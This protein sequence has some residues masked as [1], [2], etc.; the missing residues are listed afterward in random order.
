VLTWSLATDADADEFAQFACCQGARE[1]WILEV[2]NYVRG[3]V[4]R[5]AQYVLAHRNEAGTLLAVSAFDETVIGI[6]LVSPL[7]HPG[8]HLQVV[9]IS[10][11]HQNQGLSQEIFASTFNAMRQLDVDRVFVTANVHREHVMSHRACARVGLT[12]W[13]PLDDA[14]WILLGEVPTDPLPST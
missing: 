4:L 2:E 12:P 10:L 3:W 11:D 7:D 8:W 6:P 14:Y 9:A 1:P 13:I 5:R